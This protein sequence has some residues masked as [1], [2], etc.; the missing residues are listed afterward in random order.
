MNIDAQLIFVF[1]L[2]AIAVRYFIDRGRKRDNGSG[3]NNIGDCVE[4]ELN[5]LCKKKK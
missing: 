5:K 3:C 2:I 1:I 4:C